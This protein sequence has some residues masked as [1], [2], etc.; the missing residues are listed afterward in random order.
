MNTTHNTTFKKTDNIAN[1]KELLKKR[2]AV[3]IS[4]FYTPPEIQ[5]LTEQTLGCVSDSLEM[6]R[7]GASHPA[8]T[9]V[10]S[11]VRFMGETAK[12]LNPEKRVLV[13]TLEAE[14]SLDLSCPV[15]KFTEFC[16]EHPNRTVVVYVNTSAA[17][18]AL[19][20]WTVTSSSAISIIEHLDRQG[21]K[22]IFAPDKHLGWYIRKKTG[23]DMVLWDGACIVHENFK[24]AGIAELKKQYPDAAL[25]VHPESPQEVVEIAD[26][27]GSTT[28]ILQ[29]S[30]DLPNDTFII[31]TDSGLFYKLQQKSPRKTFIEAPSYGKGATCK[32]CAHC[33]WMSMNTLENLEKSLETSAT[34][35][36]LP[37][38]VISKA[39]IPLKRMLDFRK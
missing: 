20:D 13:P 10:V 25:L 37:N 19:A 5:Q 14:C 34:E 35:I 30:Q 3:M 24:A 6:A 4:H 29:A 9:L 26:M 12:I 18:K 32:S 33:P 16:K 23:A 39:S 1:I 38:E 31:A 8:K 36:I 2:D 27:V 22:I 15:D 7:F 28:Q 11:G 21:E 17:I